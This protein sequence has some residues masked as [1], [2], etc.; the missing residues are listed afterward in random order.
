MIPQFK[1][2]SLMIG[3][4]GVLAILFSSQGQSQNRLPEAKPRLG[5]NLAGPC[6]WNTELPFVDVFRMSRPWVSQKTGTKWNGGPTLSLDEHGWVTKLESD[7]WAETP[8]CTIKGGHYPSG[9]YTVLYDGK[10]KLEFRGAAK[11][12]SDDSGRTIIKVDAD[13]GGFFLKIV[14]IDSKDYIRNIRVIMPGYAKTYQDEPFHPLFLKRWQGVACFRFMDWMK[15]N[16]SDNSTWAERPTVEDATF[17]SK[18]VALEWMIDLCNR[19]SVDP[20]FCMPH[21]AD[22][23]YIR[24]FARMV[25]DRLDPK[26]K[27]YIEYSNEVWNSQF[28]QYKYAA[29]EGK[30]LGFDEGE[31]GAAYRYTAYRSVQ[32]FKIWEEVF[33]GNARLIR[34]LAT[35]TVNPSVSKQIVEF[36]DAWKNADALAI[37]SYVGTMMKIKG[38]GAG[39]DEDQV[40]AWTTDQALDYME[41]TALPKTIGWINGQKEI[42]D[43]YGLKLMSYEG[44]QHMVGRGKAV[45]NEKIVNLFHE[46]NASERMG[47][48][49]RQLFEAWTK[50]GGDLFCHFSSISLWSKWGSWGL[51]QYYDDDPLK[52]PK[53]VATLQ[54]A[55][56]SGQSVTL[57]DAD[58]QGAEL[59]NAGQG[60]AEVKKIPDQAK[61]Y[62]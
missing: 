46:A 59:Q 21:K 54:W 5:I 36:Q 61:K 17:S 34:V 15:T 7:C 50:A 10:G 29:D 57:P 42:A 56:K 2:Y 23:T 18:G 37:G 1:K 31:S 20:W 33:N 16:G 9:E 47:K 26:L 55:K 25:K 43:K 60:K 13:K 38:R 24:N 35:Q 48:I 6:D 40:E 53:F 8:C 45:G 49:Y 58:L 39:P 62:N 28:A 19:Q 51:M 11:V 12:V 3:I 27:V 32:I 44:G 52:F 22:D 14:A 41:E 4:A 30:K